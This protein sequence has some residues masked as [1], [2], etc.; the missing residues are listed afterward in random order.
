[1][2]LRD[3]REL[4]EGHRIEADLCIVGAGAAGLA[5]ADAL[6]GA[7]LR[8]A[9]LES[10]GKE[11]DAAMQSLC[12]GS[13]V[14]IQDFPLDATRLRALGGTTNHWTAWTH[15]LDPLDLEPRAWV[16]HS[17]WPLRAAELAPLYE[18]AGRFF[19]LPERPFDVAAWEDGEGVRAWRFAGGS[20]ASRIVQIVPPERR[21]LGQTLRAGLEAAPNVELYL[22]ASVLELVPDAG[23]RRVEHLALRTPEGRRFEARARAYVLAA[24]GI[25]NA[26]LL[27]LSTRASPAGLG[28]D[29]DLVGRFFQNHPEQGR[30]VD[31]L[32]TPRAPGAGF[33]AMRPARGALVVGAFALAE[34]IQRQEQLMNCG[35]R[36]ERTLALRRRGAGPAPEAGADG[37]P[38]SPGQRDGE[39][40][41][42][43]PLRRVAFDADGSGGQGGALA[44]AA[45]AP[46]PA[47]HVLRL[48]AEPAPNPESRVR[49]GDHRDAFGQRRVVLDWR[50]SDADSRSV[51]RTLERLAREWGAAGF[52]RARSRFPAAGFADFDPRGSFH[53][54]GTTR[55]HDDPNQGV[56]DRDARVHGVA[57]LWIAGSSVFPTYG[58]VNPTLTI[59]ALTLRLADHLRGALG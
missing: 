6:R 1:M 9:V 32:A 31:L 5:L 40:A 44:Q 49:L 36:I 59:V 12:A 33:Y 42:D 58:T 25:E 54:M 27:L 48:H 3:A 28:N 15:P 19:G 47:L 10:G 13:Q 20:V 53:H 50:L 23:Q 24:G 56:V 55:M 16:P 4:P 35:F 11:P 45:V 2:R 34:R 21:R 43:A 41:L 46:E 29:R 17:G 39:D 18:R 30:A 8:V 52:G 7:P 14:G 26:R 57:N 22:H 37:A 51:R 38:A